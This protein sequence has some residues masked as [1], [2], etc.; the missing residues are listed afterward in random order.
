MMHNSSPACD[1]MRGTRIYKIA[2]PAH[3]W[4]NDFVVPDCDCYDAN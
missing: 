1:G 3:E 4:I 2:K